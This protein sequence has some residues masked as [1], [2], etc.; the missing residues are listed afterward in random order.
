[1]I[2]LKSMLKHCLLYDGTLIFIRVIRETELPRWKRGKFIDYEKKPSSH[3]VS[4]WQT[5]HWKPLGVWA[6]QK[7]LKRLNGHWERREGEERSLKL[8]WWRRS[9]HNLFSSSFS[10]K[11]VV[12]MGNGET[13][14]ITTCWCCRVV[15]SHAWECSSFSFKTFSM[16]L[17]SK[18]R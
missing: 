8:C 12:R 13:Q 10:I 6:A 3:A 9:I 14:L 15:Y 18:V 1:M 2:C 7:L 4:F 5:M 16:N 17:S 11:S